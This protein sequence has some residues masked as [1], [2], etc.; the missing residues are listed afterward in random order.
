MNPGISIRF[1]TQETH[2]SPPHR[3]GG[4]RRHF[5]YFLKFPNNQGDVI[6]LTTTTNAYKRAVCRFSPIKIPGLE[7][8]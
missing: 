1:D 3:G 7:T 8:P 2:K 6:A 4:Q 5:T